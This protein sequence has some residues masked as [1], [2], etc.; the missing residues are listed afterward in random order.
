MPNKQA[1][2]TQDDLNK[3]VE[4][5][6]KQ[7]EQQESQARTAPQNAF[8]EIIRTK[9][10]DLRYQCKRLNNFYYSL[11]TQGKE[12]NNKL[13]DKNS[14]LNNLVNDLADLALAVSNDKDF[15]KNYSSY[16]DT[17][18]GIMKRASFE[19]SIE[20]YQPE[21]RVLRFL[22]KRFGPTVVG[23]LI[24]F[25]IAGPLGLIVSMKIGTLSSLLSATLIGLASGFVLSF[26]A[27]VKRFFPWGEPAGASA[28]RLDPARNV[29]HNL[30]KDSSGLLKQVDDIYYATRPGTWL[31]YEPDNAFY[32]VAGRNKIKSVAASSKKL[33][34]GSAAAS[35]SSGTLPNQSQATP[36]VSAA[37]SPVSPAPAPD[38]KSQNDKSKASGPTAQNKGAGIA[39]PPKSS[40]SPAPG[41]GQKSA[42]DK[43]SAVQAKVGEVSQAKANVGNSEKTVLFLQENNMFTRCK[44]SGLKNTV[45]IITQDDYINHVR[46]TLRGPR[47]STVATK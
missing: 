4:I 30:R 8:L 46:T 5:E 17:F 34:A 27:L 38:Q 12:A 22:S 25:L 16:L 42:E 39:V 14:N 15:N 37:K 21:N 7:R 6:D 36:G 29:P 1:G 41:P 2:L 3:E 28:A 32:A 47:S 43:S 40:T 26:T 9:Q 35:A 20:R 11:V 18:E 19:L 13:A 33:S 23:G 44:L 31:F 10:E 45:P 24:G